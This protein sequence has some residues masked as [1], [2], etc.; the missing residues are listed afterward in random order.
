MRNEKILHRVKEKRNIVHT[1][2]RR[3]DD[4]IGHMLRRD[5]LL[6]HIIEGKIE[7]NIYVMG[8][9]G[10]RCK[11]LVDDLKQTRGYWKLKQDVLDDTVWRTSFGGGCGTIVVQRN[12]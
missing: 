11:Q 10:I 1:I 8:R 3:K 7:E 12:G 5:C 6:K 2:N 9:Q 4:S